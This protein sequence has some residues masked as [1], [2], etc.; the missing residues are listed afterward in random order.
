MDGFDAI[1]KMRTKPPAIVLTDLEMHDLL[2]PKA[3]SN[4]DFTIVLLISPNPYAE[5]VIS[6]LNDCEISI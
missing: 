1:E 4:R 3:G 2:Y 6:Y 5:S